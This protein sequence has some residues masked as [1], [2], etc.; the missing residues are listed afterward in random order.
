M[1]NIRR[2]ASKHV[3]GQSLGMSQI[4]SHV[5]LEPIRKLTIFWRSQRTFDGYTCLIADFFLRES[6]LLSESL[7]AIMVYDIF[8][9]K[10]EVCG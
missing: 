3:L 9:C 6:G 5:A 4:G 7:I 2:R 10:L 1:L 8:I